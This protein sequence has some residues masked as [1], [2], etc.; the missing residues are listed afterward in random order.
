MW[1]TLY[2]RRFYL[3]IVIIGA[4]CAAYY[5]YAGKGIGETVSAVPPS[6]E[7]GV[8]LFPAPGKTVYQMGLYL[9]INARILYGNTVLNTVNS[10]GQP[11]HSLYFTAY[12]NAFRDLEE[13][14][15]PRTAY[16][17]GFDEGWLEF[18]KF[19]INGEEVE[20][21]QNGVSVEAVLLR[22]IIP[23]ENIV[24]EMEWRAKVPKLAYRYG[25]KDAVYM[26]GNFYPFLNVFSDEGWHNSCN[27]AFGEPF[28]IHCA[29]YIVRLNIP[30]AYD[31]VSTGIVTE[32]FAEDNG[33]ETYIVKAE[34]ARD[35]SLVVMHNYR[36]L[37][38]K[39]NK[40]AV[41]CYAP[42]RSIDCAEDILRETVEIIKYYSCVWGSYPYPDFKVVFVPIEGFHGME[43]SGLIFLREGFLNPGYNKEHSEFILAHEIAHQWWYGIV[44]N[45]QLREP[46]LD[47]G[48]ANWSAYKYLEHY[49][50]ISPFSYDKLGTSVDLA[51][52]LTDMYSAHEYYRTAYYGGEAFWFGL[53]EELG[54]EKVHKVLR[55]YL[56]DYRFKIANTQGLLAVIRK[57][58]N[59][60]MRDYFSKWFSSYTVAP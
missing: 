1:I 22:D 7:T 53:E 48:L 14:P 25:T 34:N 8:Y 9:D 60:D 15:A 13:T 56:A 11:L 44:G 21:F 54:E 38:A 12:P 10:S 3:W 27:S 52:K 59:R 46:W 36:G 18:E 17:A 4:V 42:S 51:Q 49:K 40:T 2:K 37:T 26:L 30:E 23:G 50:G 57:E 31:I 28:C 29:D 20:F 58:A 35:F 6:K 32:V 24:V 16:Y 45:D 5:I 55:R 47:E 43:Y 33:R 19:K 41:M 39:Q